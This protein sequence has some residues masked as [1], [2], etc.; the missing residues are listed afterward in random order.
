M[1]II[2]LSVIFLLALTACNS[3]N[4]TEPQADEYYQQWKAQKIHNYIIDQVHY[5]FCPYRGVSVRITVKSDTVFNIVKISDNTKLN[6]KYYITIDSL[7]S[8]IKNSS[9]DSIVVK[10]NNQYGFPEYIDINPQD[11]PFDGRF[12]Y[13]TS[14][15]KP[16]ISFPN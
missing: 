15:F 12:L 11:E 10:Y 16:I 3:D 1:K 8:I 4:V 2:I 5:C 9:A 6:E 14:N 7:F 13:Q